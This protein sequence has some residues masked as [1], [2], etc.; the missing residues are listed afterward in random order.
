[1]LTREIQII[2]SIV[3]LTQIEKKIYKKIAH[4]HQDTLDLV[5]FLQKQNYKINNLQNLWTELFHILWP[6][7]TDQNPFL[8]PSPKTPLHP[9]PNKTLTLSKQETRRRLF[10]INASLW[11]SSQPFL[12]P[13]QISPYFFLDIFFFLSQQQTLF[14]MSTPS[15]Q[16]TTTTLL[17]SPQT[18]PPWPI[19]FHISPLPLSVLP[20]IPPWA[21]VAQVAPMT[22]RTRENPT[23]Q[24][25]TTMEVE[26]EAQLHPQP[27]HHH[28]LSPTIYSMHSTHLWQ[29]YM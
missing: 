28:H 27:P 20:S 19:S 15:L 11:Y 13:F 5:N 21:T 14:F 8:F 16:K 3:V 29:I 25:T 10:P 7:I 22:L 9:C 12:T 23:N 18:T 4:Q 6:V 24:P 26:A 17:F 2:S 1:M